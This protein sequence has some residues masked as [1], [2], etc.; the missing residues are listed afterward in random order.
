MKYALQII[1][2]YHL[3]KIPAIILSCE[4][5]KYFFNI[6]ETTQR[7]S[8][9]HSLK[10]ISGSNIFLTQLSTHHITGMYGL[11]L[12]L[13]EHKMC[14]GSKIYGPPGL[15]DYLDSI[16]FLMGFRLL[17]YSIYDFGPHEKKILVVNNVQILEKITSHPKF[18][19]IFYNINRY[20]SEEQKKTQ[21]FEK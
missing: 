20:L 9:E 21:N 7:F 12:T 4:N 11:L 13:F 3:Q 19:T 6:P 2:G 1:E 8:K 16:R 15:C 17:P 14:F 18:N 10:F 5:Q